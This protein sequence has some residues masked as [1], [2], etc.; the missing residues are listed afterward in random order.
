MAIVPEPPLANALPS[1]KRRVKLNCT[2][3]FL[4]RLDAARIE[5]NVFNESFLVGGVD[6]R[7]S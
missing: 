4:E 1:L 5:C 7:A 6:H 2:S 3:T